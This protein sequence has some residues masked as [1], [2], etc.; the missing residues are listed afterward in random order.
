[1]STTVRLGFAVSS[2]RAVRLFTAMFILAAMIAPEIA[3][4]RSARAASAVTTSSLNLRA[5]PRTDQRVR[6]VMPAGAE[7]EIIGGPRRGFYKV[8]H[9]GLAG[10]AHG[11]YLDLSGGGGDDGGSSGSTAVLSSLNLRTGP[12]TSSAVILV[13][14]RGARVDLTGDSDNG[15]L[16]VVY[17]GTFGWAYSEYLEGGTSG[18]DDGGGSLPTGSGGG[19][20]TVDSALNLR[21][22][23][24]TG[25]SVILIMP[26]GAGVE[27]T[28]DEA[29]GFLG[30]IYNGTR[31][32]AYGQYLNTGGGGND[33][34]VDGSDGWSTDEI[35]AII[36]AA[37]D[38]YGQS[39]E[40]MLR[41]ARCESNLDPYN[42]TPPYSA[43][44]LFQF[45]PGTWASTPY[46]NDDI[47]DPVANAN[48]AGWMWSVGRRNEWV[49]Q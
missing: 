35:I 9:N 2:R 8:V 30:V 19:W 13:M 1:M 22:G 40:D 24:S 45:L 49:C 39:R 32:W 6:R 25:D 17:R 12:S 26:G 31:G 16:G 7:V 18:G 46:A 29:N 38:R 28:G 44:G 42:V 48:A 20:A 34:S 21:S 14:P 37:A 4:P 10:W 15:F 23:P 11:D 27:L 43:S 3:S 33:G 5:G 36:N 41:V 47:F